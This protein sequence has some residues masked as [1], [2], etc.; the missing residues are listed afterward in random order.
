MINLYSIL[1]QE[2]RRRKVENDWIWGWPFFFK[3]RCN[4][5]FSLRK[6]HI[7]LCI[8]YL[9]CRREN[10]VV[11][12]LNQISVVLARNLHQFWELVS[13]PNFTELICIIR[14]NYAIQSLRQ[15]TLYICGCTL[16]LFIKQENLFLIFSLFSL[17]LSLL[18]FS[19]SKIFSSL[20]Q[21]LVFS[22][23]DSFNIEIVLYNPLRKSSWYQSLRF[24]Y[25]TQ[26]WQL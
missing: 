4:A 20:K 11:K 1:D 2:H 9:S 8:W 5:P 6:K 21:S 7:V 19:F 14:I 24:L 26:Q 22:S 23:I 13:S 16:S 15:I 25:K 3:S 10:D 17:S 12:C 18:L